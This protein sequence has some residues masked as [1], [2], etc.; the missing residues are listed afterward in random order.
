[1]KI[2]FVYDVIYPY[3]KGGVEKRIWELAVRLSSRG[4][5]VHIVGMKFWEGPDSVKKD[6][7]TLHGICPPQPLYA[8]GR[9]TISEA[10]NFS[11]RLIP[12]L[13]REEFDIIDCQQFPYFSCISTK[14]ISHLKKTPMVITWIE[15]WGDYWYDYLGKKGYWGR[16]I[17]KCV[18]RISSQKIAIS[19][20]TASRLMSV[21]GSPVNVIIPA[22]I[23]GAA[24]RTILR[25]RERSDVIFIGRLIREKNA[26]LLVHATCELIRIH[27]EICVI[28]VGEGPEFTRIQE[29]INENRLGKNIAVHP[30]FDDH[31]DLIALLKASRV[32]VLPSVREGFGI[33]ALEAL[34]CG[35]PVVTLDHPANAVRDL[36][37][38]KTGFLCRASAEDLALK[39]QIALEKHDEMRNSC[40]FTAES[41]E[42]ER[43]VVDLE[44]FYISVAGTGGK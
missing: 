9:R 4:H 7:V 23:E 1:M 14:I 44:N 28:I 33:T 31:H 30:F 43:I 5:D 2:A 12:F 17:E 29:I 34:A 25:A 38:E 36:V 11:A 10:I 39:I 18:T 35:L 26:D 8:D 20:L 27:P 40:I 22:G 15:V 32:F 6:G 37:T 24:I 3:V 16:L 13:M 41:Y 21:Y 19:R 42:W